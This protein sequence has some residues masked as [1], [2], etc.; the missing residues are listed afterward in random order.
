MEHELLGTWRLV[1]WENRTLAGEVTYPMGPDAVGYLTYT[2]DGYVFVAIMRAERLAFIA[3]DPLG[4]SEE[5][6]A[7]AA[8]GY[9]SYAGTYERQG[10]TVTHHVKASLFPNWV[11]TNQERRVGWDGARLLLSTAPTVFA[12]RQQTAHLV[13]ERVTEAGAEEPRG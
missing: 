12:E 8:A 3:G 10:D 7:T 6:R 9:V 4:G 13:W 5:E 11:G 1:S 2:A